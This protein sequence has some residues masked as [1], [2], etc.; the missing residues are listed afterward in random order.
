MT[1]RRLPASVITPKK[2]IAKTNIPITQDAP[3]DSKLFIKWQQRWDGNEER[4]GSGA[5]EMYKQR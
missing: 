5:V 3:I 1:P 2:R 4:Y